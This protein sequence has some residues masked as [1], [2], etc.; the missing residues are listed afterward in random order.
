MKNLTE[1]KNAFS[2]VRT[3]ARRIAPEATALDHSAM[4]AIMFNKALF[5]FHNLTFIRRVSYVWSK[6]YAQ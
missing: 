4:N 2:G 1:T 3:H 6:R 5:M